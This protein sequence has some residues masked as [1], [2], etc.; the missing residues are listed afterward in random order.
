MFVDWINQSITIFQVRNILKDCDLLFITNQIANNY[1]S[2][3]TPR[4]SATAFCQTVGMAINVEKHVHENVL[5]H[6]FDRLQQNLIG[7]RHKCITLFY[8]S[9][10]YLV[11]EQFHTCGTIS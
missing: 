4:K 7:F 8:L 5:S 6:A 2:F 10:R 9:E 3:M 11:L 1:P